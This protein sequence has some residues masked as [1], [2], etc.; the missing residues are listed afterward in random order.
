MSVMKGTC[1][2]PLKRAVSSLAE[3]RS[4]SL[5]RWAG[6]G[7][8]RVLA[9]TSIASA[10]VA[11]AGVVAAVTLTGGPQSHDKASLTGSSSQ[12][13][14]VTPPF[15][16]VANVMPPVAS[17]CATPTAFTYSGTLSATAP[18]TVKYQWVYSSGK[19]GPLQTVRF[20]SAGHRAVAG[21]TVKSRTA[22]SGWG[23]IK[24]IAPVDRTSNEA[25]YRLLCGGSSGGGVSARAVV[26]PTAMTGSCVTARPAFTATGSITSRKADRVTYYWAQSDG[27]NS[28]PTTLT[29]TKPGTQAVEP[30]TII[31]PS[32]SGSGEAVLVVTSPATA[33]SRPAIYT[34]TCKA[35]G[36]SQSAPG[37]HPTPS[38]AVPATASAPAGNPPMSITVNAPTTA[39][40]GQPYSGT[41]S[42]TGGDGHYT[43]TAASG[44]PAGLTATAN[45]ATLTITGTP[46][47]VGNAL[48]HGKASDRE[49]NPQTAG[50]DVYFTIVQP[51]ITITANVPTP[52]TVGEPYL[53]TATATGGDGTTFTWTVIGL[54]EGLTA[55]PN[56]A[57]LTISGT[58]TASDLPASNPPPPGS[59]N[60]DV[61]VS[62]GTISASRTLSM[63]VSPPS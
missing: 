34:L 61:I 9:I 40:L 58:P 39:S 4:P 12:A 42:V 2:P 47:V 53:G 59:F 55:A 22:G 19:P 24:I 17:K 15:N 46:T 29:F 44:L 7:R 48:A 1:Y 33:A 25:T 23:E 13:L 5:S 60:V 30:L 37:A 41:L 8:R 11:V 6:D 54:P 21:A 32:V 10:V 3:G 27:A 26:S 52:A 62:D 14:S 57:R 28:A 51:P 20:R 50:W 18:G 43:W 36:A 56:G 63:L 45:G 38:N 35:F 49:A 16:A 31:P